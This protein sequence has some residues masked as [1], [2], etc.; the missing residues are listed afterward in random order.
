MWFRR[1]IV[2]MTLS[3]NTRFIPTLIWTLSILVVA[4]GISIVF[5]MV[6]PWGVWWNCLRSI[7]VIAIATTL[8]I[9]EYMTSLV[10][11]YAREA[12]S[13]GQWVPFRLRWSP[14]HRREFSAIMGAILV[15]F[16]M[17]TIQKPGYSVMA[18]FLVSLA[19]CL[20]AFCRLTSAE[21]TREDMGIPDSRDTMFDEQVASIRSERANRKKRHGKR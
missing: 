16:A 12:E 15:V 10:F 1:F 7:P 11:H 4:S 14:R 8:F 5:D 19:A 3:Y 17:S 18:G 13:D 20:A 9:I 21:R 2:W 6:L